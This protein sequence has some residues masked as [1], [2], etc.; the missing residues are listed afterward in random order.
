MKSSILGRSFI[1]EGAVV[2]RASVNT[3]EIGGSVFREV[4]ESADIS[5][6]VELMTPIILQWISGRAPVCGFQVRWHTCDVCE[7]DMPSRITLTPYHGVGQVDVI[8]DVGDFSP[9]QVMTLYRRVDGKSTTSVR[10]RCGCGSVRC[11]RSVC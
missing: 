7:T 5:M 10:R 8:L 1:N 6:N 2:A 3:M 9:S 11:S 4:N